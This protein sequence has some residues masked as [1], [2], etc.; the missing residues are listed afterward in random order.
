MTGRR[1]AFA[2]LQIEP[3][4]L[5]PAIIDPQTDAATPFNYL[6]DEDEGGATAGPLLPPGWP[7]ILEVSWLRAFC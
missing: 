4:I 6:D 2:V 3:R 1:E 5:S 7:G